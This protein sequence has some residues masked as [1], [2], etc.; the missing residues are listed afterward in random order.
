MGLHMERGNHAANWKKMAICGLHCFT[1]ALGAFITVAGTYTVVQ[2][3]IN[4]YKSGQV[5]GA[6]TC[7]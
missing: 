5:G 1:I 2:S 3:I 6:F 4:A 7:S